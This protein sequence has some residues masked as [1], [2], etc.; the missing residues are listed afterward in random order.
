VRKSTRDLHRFALNG[1]LAALW[2]LVCCS[3]FVRRC[4]GPANLAS[5]LWVAMKPLRGVPASWR[6]S[7]LLG[8]IRRDAASEA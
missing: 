5:M 3:L 1:A 8:H 6:E 2:A 4:P 7:L